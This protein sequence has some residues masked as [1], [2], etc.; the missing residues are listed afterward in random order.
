MR[1]KKPN[2]WDYKKPN[3][4][5]YLLLPLTFPFIIN[6]FLLNIKKKN[7][8]YEEIKTIC[9]GNIYVG[10]TAKTPLAIKINSILKNLNIKTAIIKKYYANQI[11][12]QKLLKKK[13]KLYCS[14]NRKIALK[15]A[16]LDNYK[17]AIF[18]DGLQDSSINYDLS[19]VCFNSTKWI[20]NGFLIPSGPLR[21]K[22]QSLSKYDA[23]FF[24]GNKEDISYLK[25]LVKKFNNNIKI[26]ETHYSP[27]NSDKFD[28][29]DK[30]LIF[31]G[32]GNPDIF[33]E[34]LTKNK[35]NIVKEIKFP[36]HYSYTKNDIDKIRMIAKNFDA[37]ILT[38]EKDYVKID[39]RY[40]YDINFFEIELFIKDEHE[41]INLL[42]LNI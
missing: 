2:F 25:I 29:N 4:L 20:G 19:F 7:K 5:S 3:L 21:E 11:D 28:K 39:S 14:R 35:F 34:T 31:S 26:F 12:E 36:D 42:K 1:L 6:N 13:T 17:V 24:N 10:G 41:L 37:K 8:K 18:D 38:T 33:K 9:I 16:L 40:L 27:I 15:H 32:I 30:Y 22:L 23:V